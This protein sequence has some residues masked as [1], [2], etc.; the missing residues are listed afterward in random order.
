V[1]LVITDAEGAPLPVEPEV[2]PLH[3]T[4]EIDAAIAAASAGRTPLSGTVRR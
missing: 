4:M 2:Q 3:A 1:V